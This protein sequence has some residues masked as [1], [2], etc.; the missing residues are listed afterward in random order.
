MVDPNTS[1]CAARPAPTVP[2]SKAGAVLTDAERGQMIAF[3]QTH[4][5]AGRLSYSEVGAMLDRAAEDGFH[6]VK[7]ASDA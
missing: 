5:P 2:D 1:K 7:V 6:F 4:T 3:L